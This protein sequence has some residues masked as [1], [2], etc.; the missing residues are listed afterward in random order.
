[1]PLVCESES[2]GVAVVVAAAIIIDNHIN[3]V[4]SYLSCCSPISSVFAPTIGFG[5]F[6]RQ[7]AMDK[8]PVDLISNSM[9][10]GTTMKRQK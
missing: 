3:S 5:Y 9:A 1:M 7:F 6:L 10:D 2:I 8:N 4:L